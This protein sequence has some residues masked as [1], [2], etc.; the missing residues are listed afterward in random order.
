MFGGLLANPNQEPELEEELPSLVEAEA[1][2]DLPS[3]VPDTTAQSRPP[4]SG[5]RAQERAGKLN[6]ALG[7]DSPGMPELLHAIQEGTEDS[8]RQRLADAESLKQRELKI[9]VIKEKAQSGTP[10]TPEDV[11]FMTDITGYDPRANPETILERKFAGAIV[12]SLT[13]IGPDTEKS[14]IAQGYRKDPEGLSRQMS[15]A[16]ELMTRQEIVKNVLSD[17]ETQYQDQSWAAWGWDT[18]KTVFPLYSALKLGWGSERTDAWLKG[19]M[20]QDMVNEYWSMPPDQM[21]VELRKDLAGLAKDNL[22]LAREVAHAVLSHTSGQQFLDNAFTVFDAATFPGV[23]SVVKG[24][25]TGAELGLNRAARAPVDF[26]KPA[27]SEAPGAAESV[28]K[29]TVRANA[30]P[31]TD[32]GRQLNDM[33]D[34]QRAAELR[35]TSRAEQIF[36]G[37]GTI[38]D[39]KQIADDVPSIFRPD[40]IVEGLAPNLA[41]NMGRRLMSRLQQNSEKISDTVANLVKVGRL[42]EEALQVAIRNEAK[43]LQDDFL[44]P[45]DAILEVRWVRPDDTASNVGR[46]GLYFGKKDGNLFATPDEAVSYVR[47]HYG[48]EPMEFTVQSQGQGFAAVV[49][50]HL[51]ETDS[52]V[53]AQVRV[54]DNVK[55]SLAN[56]FLGWLRTADDRVSAQQRGN[57]LAVVHGRSALEDAFRSSIDNIGRMTKRDTE[58]LALVMKKNRTEPD[59]RWTGEGEPP[60]GNFYDTAQDFAES[61]H[62]VHG[63]FPSEQQ[64]LAYFTYR[65]LNDWDWV[66]R[67]MGVYRDKAR[68]GTESILLKMSD[69]GPDGRVQKNEVFDGKTIKS[70]PWNAKEDAGIV[71]HRDGQPHEYYRLQAANSSPEQKDKIEGLLKE[72]YKLI[73]VDNPTRIPGEGRL[74]NET[75]N[76]VLTKD[77]EVRPISYKQIPY[78]PGWHVEYPQEWFVKQPKITQKGGDKEV[79]RTRAQYEDID[80]VYTEETK[81]PPKPREP[82]AERI[83]GVDADRVRT[84]LKE[85]SKELKAVSDTNTGFYSSADKY[86]IALK[87]EQDNLYFAAKGEGFAEKEAA[88][89][90]AR[91]DYE[92][93]L[94]A[95]ENWTPEKVEKTR[96]VRKAVGEETITEKS[97]LPPRNVYEGDQAVLAFSTKAEADKYAQ[98]METARK[99]LDGDDAQ[100]DAFL[101][102]NL[103]YDAKSFRELFEARIKDDGTELPPLLDRSAP[104]LRTFTGNTTTDEYGDLLRGQFENLEDTVRSQWNRFQNV[105]KKFVGQ[106]DDPLWT[107]KESGSELNPKLSLGNAEPIDPVLSVAKAM[108]NVIRSR[109]FSDYKIS[110]VEAWAQQFGHLLKDVSKEQLEA[111][112]VFHIHNPVWR[113]DLANVGEMSVAKNSR[114]ALLELLGTS[115][116]ITTRTDH[117]RHLMMSS[118]YDKYGQGASEAAVNSYL[119][120]ADK[121]PISLMRKVAFHV[122]IG[123]Y[124]PYQLLMNSMTMMNA[125]AIAGPKNGFSGAAAALPMRFAMADERIL[126]KMSRVSSSFGWKPEH[127]KEAYEELKKSGKFHIEGEHTWKDDIADPPVAVNSMGQSILNGGLVFFRE[128][129]RITRLA[130][131]N[132]AYLEWR[133]LNPTA[134]INDTV[135][136]ELMTRSD[137]MAANMTRASNASWQQ[138]V[139]SLPAQFL[140]YHTRLAEQMLGKRLTGA[141]KA[142]LIGMNSLMY[143][144]PIGVLGSSGVGSLAGGQYPLHEE[145]RKEFLKRNIPMDDPMMVAFHGGLVNLLSHV[146]T[147]SDTDLASKLGPTGGQLFKNLFFDDKS[148]IESFFGASGSKAASIWSSLDPGMKAVMAPFRADEKDFP[149]K[150]EDVVD[151]LRNVKSVDHAVNIYYALNAGKI[152]AKNGQLQTEVSPMEAVFTVLTGGQPRRVT[153]A[154]LM[155]GMNIDRAKVLKDVM[156]ETQR[157]ADAMY[158][159]YA[160][161]DT[162]TGRIYEK[163]I[164]TRMQLADVPMKD[165]A[166][167]LR[168]VVGINRESVERII[169]DFNTKSAPASRQQQGMEFLIERDKKRQN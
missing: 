56:T 131:W 21:A 3:I 133:K 5:Q 80:E 53:R 82:K 16:E 105:D 12:N 168:Q 98:R 159:A 29:D 138:G 123:L 132:A 154:M 158:K 19:T 64:T 151:V 111:N 39:Q 103:P 61:F 164:A 42:P 143:G 70:M 48:L 137:L 77:V 102:G 135:R 84:R 129:E 78:R 23:A 86:R 107:V 169:L 32:A 59:S 127:F 72:G 50:R 109:H 20:V 130:S 145:V 136:R 150:S 1:P 15:V 45:E 92:K 90:K 46:V 95:W 113:E 10:V 119:Y 27:V 163:R 22:V 147:G 75:V 121:D 8:L 43:R 117:V 38:R 17:I 99:L 65:Q 66:M 87:S 115:S 149:L 62:S 146:V 94:A 106:R 116:E 125:I 122:N 25:R 166:N 44:G 34:V 14:P 81:R 71:V 83:G 54:S 13:F 157:D 6:F 55:P 52:L 134:V 126:D 114:R 9:Q 167:I 11:R 79:T 35:V 96:K 141:E 101:K 30:S 18:A 120:K 49:T 144:I 161:N 67:N 76:F 110:H 89:L 31:T 162:E 156:K 51:D 40:T 36:T 97:S 7:Q 74:G 100:L 142:R 140:S 41:Q 68:Q 26:S 160:N 28:L 104:F 165:R 139:L 153:D 85:I 69:D 63:R 2:E 152:F 73:Q 93:E 88:A 47:N 108:S 128:G 148:L 91:A 4:L 124:N 37:Q 33:G 60:T 58:D 118:I 24:A 112:P 155:Q 57:R